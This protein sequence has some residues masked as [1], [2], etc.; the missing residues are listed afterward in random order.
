M[1]HI[2]VAAG[3]KRVVQLLGPM[4]RKGPDGADVDIAVLEAG[5][6]DVNMLAPVPVPRGDEELEGTGLAQM[7][8]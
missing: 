7:V 4:V 8:A 6:V 3:V 5:L 1:L 2:A